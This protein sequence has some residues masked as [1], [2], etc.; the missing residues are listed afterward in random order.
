M[1]C[2]NN[3]GYGIRVLQPQ[4]Y[5]LKL[6]GKWYSAIGMLST[7]GIQDVYVAEGSA[8]GE[9]FLDFIRR[10][11][12]SILVPFD[13]V[14]ANSVVVMDKASIHHVDPVVE[15]ILS[16]GELIRFLPPYSPDM[17]PK[18]CLGRSNITYK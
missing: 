16:I 1:L 15:T 13:G 12:I 11:L 5:S 8:N 2:G 6:R 10:S 17:N 3:Y 14:S 4:D 9:I 18:K 7:G